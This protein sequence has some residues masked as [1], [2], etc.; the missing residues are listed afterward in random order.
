MQSPVQRRERYLGILGWIR[1]ALC[2]LGLRRNL[3]GFDLLHL[4]RGLHPLL[5]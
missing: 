1:A 5:F 2:R 3:P 4:G